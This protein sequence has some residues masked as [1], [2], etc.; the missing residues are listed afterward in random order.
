MN[1]KKIV[2]IFLISILFTVTVMG[3][4]IPIIFSGHLVAGI[5]GI[6][7]IYIIMTLYSYKLIH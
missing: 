3:V 5:I 1:R 4:I 6:I 2:R 7:L